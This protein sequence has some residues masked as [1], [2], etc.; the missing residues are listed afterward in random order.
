MDRL[1]ELRAEEAALLERAR[2]MLDTFP[3]PS[4]GT[5]NQAEWNSNMNRF[6]Q[7]RAEIVALEDAAEND[8]AA[9]NPQTTSPIP[10]GIQSVRAQADV[11]GLVQQ[12]NASFEDFKATQN[13][14]VGNLEAALDSANT[15]A[16]ALEMNGPTP[17]LTAPHVGVKALRNYGE[18]KAHFSS[19]EGY[20][21]DPVSL[22]D[23][24]RGVAGMQSTAAVN[25]ALSVGTNTAGGFS[26]PS[27]TMPQILSALTPV[28]SLLT[29]G[30]GI[31]PME[32]GA[33][34]ATTAV[35]DTVPTASWRQERGA[36]AESDPAF[37]AVV[38]TPQSLAFYF[39]VSR[40]LLADGQGI[41]AALQEAI[42]QAF[43]KALDYAGL[44]GSGTAPEPLGIRNTA[45]VNIIPS[46]T[47]GG[48]LAG[49]GSF[50]TAIEALLNANAPMPTAA[51][52]APRSLVKLGGL[53]DTTGQPL[54]KPEL[55]ATLPLIATP[56]V[57]IALTTGTS[58][59]TSEIYMG[60]FSKMYFL[61]R[62]NLS[63]QLLRETFA[64][65]GELAF[66]CHVRADVVITH[67]KA[68]AVV[69]GV[70]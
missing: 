59:D 19:K 63:I 28:S 25:A 66:L 47:N 64:T 53:V 32:S 5:E 27:Q 35:V 67:P 14:R 44:R 24:M 54:R 12:I 18:F 9:S 37:R 69:T 34:S 38:A 2:A 33:K 22:T 13:E 10:R 6:T 41:E 30:A 17:A 50:M 43:A 60:D 62:E 45:G 29:A 56:Q 15:R 21:A 68:F 70:R 49:Y 46:G 23:F 42:A 4:W 20:S 36:V 39:R 58:S 52:M 55:L 65:T 8:D 31:V 40:E 16:A 1:N 3:G 61:M 57:P 11:T 51:I 48:A 7:I 26:V